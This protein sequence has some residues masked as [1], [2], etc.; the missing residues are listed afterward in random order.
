[1]KTWNKKEISRESALSLHN[2]FG[3]GPLE[4]S[5]FAR[6]GI[7]AGSDLLYYLESDA[8]FL[9]KPFDFSQ[10][11]DAV[12][13]ILAAVEEGEKVLIFGDRDVDGI[14]ATAVLYEQLKRMGVDVSWRLPAGDDAYG[15]SM[16]AVEDFAKNYGSLLITVDCGISNFAEIQRAGELG[17]SVIVTDH[18]N[19]PERLPAAE[20][21]VNPKCQDSGYPFGEISGCAVA[22][23]LVQALRFSQT[24]IYKQ[25]ICLL[26]V[27][28]ESVVECLKLRN[29]VKRKTFEKDFSGGTLSLSSSGLL[30]FLRG[31]QIFV[32]DAPAVSLALKN[33]F[34]SGV[35][36]NLFDV[37][38][39]AA[40]IIPSLSKKSLRALSGLSKVA[41]YSDEAG[42]EL[43]AFYNIFVTYLNKKIERGFPS[44]KAADERDLQLVMLSTLSDIMPLKN[45]NRIFVKL[46]LDSINKGKAR[47]GLVELLSRQGLLGKRL[48]AKDLSWNVIPA[49]NA[50]GR[51]GTP[52][53]S[54]RLFLAET[55]GEREE[56]AQKILDHNEERKKLE[57]ASWEYLGG[58]P[59][60][61][62]QK[63]NG[64][65]CLI[66]EEK[67]H[68]GVVGRIAAKLVQRANVPAIAMT[69]I[70]DV[71]IGS[72]RTARG[73]HCTDFLDKFGDIYINH[74]GHAGAAGFS[75]TAE[76]FE[77]FQQKIG[78]LVQE[79]VLGEDEDKTVDIDAELGGQYVNDDLMAVVDLLEPY[80]NENPELVF[81]TKNARISAGQVLGKGE[82]Q[83]LK[84]Y[85]EI[86]KQKWPALWWD[87]GARYKSEF[88][89]GDFVDVAYNFQRNTFN[90]HEGRQLQ[91]VDCKLSR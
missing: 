31:E 39:E 22:F 88:N 7:T 64:K 42:G 89:D 63:F 36:F 71:Y 51:L 18:H 28:D 66:V 12:D 75:L 76:K 4:A 6:R 84:L 58:R 32:W 23:K 43:E 87:Q 85:L 59:E 54:L 33:L 19:P 25:D 1:M 91:I 21:I 68:R 57:N 80:G 72:M 81:M 53:D 27:R 8:R 13:R 50:A 38:P 35:E 24:E 34:G 2:R 11:E 73:V 47:A 40:K 83:H 20:I 61:S 82:R 10:M 9:N 48:C 29:M 60:K 49:L 46:A 45:E 44:A 3:L 79:M 67:I 70:D 78:G 55:P 17:I 15:L 5:I 74:G 69:K 14:T 30:E 26:N 62:L 65:F 52:E 77:T 90:G 41:L 56:Y 37:R 86:G 16:A